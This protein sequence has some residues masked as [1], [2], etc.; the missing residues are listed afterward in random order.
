MMNE[1]REMLGEAARQLWPSTV[2]PGSLR[3]SWLA[4]DFGHLLFS[5][6]LCMGIYFS[7]EIPEFSVLSENLTKP[8][9]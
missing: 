5:S 6:H 1:L 8:A 2:F 7:V 3:R 4:C 9:F